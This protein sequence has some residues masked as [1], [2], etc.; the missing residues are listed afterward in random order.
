VCTCVHVGIAYACLPPHTHDIH[1]PPPLSRTPAGI[2][3]FADSQFGHVFARG[4]TREEARRN[5]VLTL[6]QME[7]R[8][9]IRTTVDYLVQLLETEAFKT[10]KIDT[11]W[12]DGII[13]EKSVSTEQDPHVTVACAAI[14]RAFEQATEREKDHVEQLA[15]GQL[16]MAPLAT[17]TSFPLEIT[18]K[19]VKYS[20]DVKRTAADTFAFTIEGGTWDAKLRAQPDGSLLATFG[21]S[22]RKIVGHEEP[23]GLRVAIDSSTVYLPN[24]FD[25]SELRTDVTGKVVRFLQ[26][27]GGRVE[28]G[29]PFVEVEA[30]K[31]IMPLKVNNEP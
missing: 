13:R 22:T 16:G 17:A 11:A 19:S 3:E 10:N 9:E 27:N 20:F 4:P 7:V 18:Y 23:L 15:M 8:G 21:G 5:L 29:Q 31:M 24:V 1:A 30:M 14:Y 2:H 28:K 25:P 26:D 6:K 12:L